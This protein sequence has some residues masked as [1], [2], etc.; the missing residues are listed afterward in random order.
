MSAQI[1][2]ADIEQPATDAARYCEHSG[3]DH[4]DNVGF[5]IAFS[6]FRLAFQGLA[7]QAADGNASSRDAAELGTFVEPIAELALEATVEGAA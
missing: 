3:I 5:Y 4:I 1:G 7:K 6:F 2:S